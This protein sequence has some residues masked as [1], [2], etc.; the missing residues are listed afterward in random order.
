VYTVADSESDSLELQFKAAR[1]LL[2]KIMSLLMKIIILVITAFAFKVTASKKTGNNTNLN[3]YRT[4][5]LTE[6]VAFSRFIA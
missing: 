6:K 3:N 1:G 5:A 2:M 4:C